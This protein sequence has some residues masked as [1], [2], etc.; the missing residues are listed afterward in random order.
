MVEVPLLNSGRAAGTVSS[1]DVVV[2]VQSFFVAAVAA[3]AV[4]VDMAMRILILMQM[5]FLNK[6]A[7]LAA[8]L[9]D[10]L[11]NEFL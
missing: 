10:A 8:L 6:V 9:V 11:E 7:V 5:L 4:V 1:V 2:V 3:V